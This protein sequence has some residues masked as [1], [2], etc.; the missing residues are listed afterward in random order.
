MRGFLHF[1]EKSGFPAGQVVSGTDAGE[2]PIADPDPGRARRDEATHLRQ[3]H[4]QGHLANQRGFS[5]HVGAGDNQDL[6]GLGIEVDVIGD[7]P[8]WCG[9]ALDHG[10]TSVGKVEQIPVVHIGPA[11][12]TV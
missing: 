9:D 5:R 1:D 2:D 10:M 4:G 11:V 12:T 3:D 7:E 6:L 8:A